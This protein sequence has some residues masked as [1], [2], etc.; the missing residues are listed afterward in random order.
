MPTKLSCS[1]AE[2]RMYTHRKTVLNSKLGE[3]VHKKIK[4]SRSLRVVVVENVPEVSRNTIHNNQPDAAMPTYQ[5]TKEVSCRNQF[6]I[7]LTPKI[8]NP[9]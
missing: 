4:H 2:P 6:Q 1:K 8:I 9:L 5:I 7:T 3:Q